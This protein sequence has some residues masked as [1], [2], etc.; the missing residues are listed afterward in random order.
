MLTNVQSISP[1]H[2]YFHVSENE[3]E[4]LRESQSKS[5]GAAA[6]P[7]EN[8][9][10][11]TKVAESKATETKVT[12]GLSHGRDFPYEGTIDFAEL[13]VDPSTGKQL[14]RAVIENKDGALL[15]GLFVRSPDSCRRR[16]SPTDGR[17]SLDR[18]GSARRLRAS[19]Q[20]QERR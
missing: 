10:T 12:V 14:R 4:L 18:H 5:D 13:G 17:G 15:P 19:R 16:N 9:V 11:Q 7:A 20:R 3:L 1:I 8:K 6:T 2:A